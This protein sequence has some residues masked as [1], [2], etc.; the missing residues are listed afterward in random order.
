[1]NNN[2]NTSVRISLDCL[3]LQSHIEWCH[4]IQYIRLL[5]ENSKTHVN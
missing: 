4:G 1:M 5:S 2:T 3:K